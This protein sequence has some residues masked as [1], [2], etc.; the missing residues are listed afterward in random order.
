MWTDGVEIRTPN[1]SVKLTFFIIDR[2]RLD[3]IQLEQ[4]HSEHACAMS[5]ERF[6]FT[7]VYIICTYNLCSLNT[8]N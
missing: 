6:Y 7:D 5:V 3:N 2:N 4:V 8:S 1:I